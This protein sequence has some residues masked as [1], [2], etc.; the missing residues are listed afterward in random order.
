MRIRRITA[1]R[2][3][4][5]D[6]GQFLVVGLVQYPLFEYIQPFVQLQ[7]QR[8]ELGVERADQRMQHPDRVAAELRPDRACLAQRVKGRAL[9]AAQR[10][11]ESGGVVA[12]HFDGLAELLIEAETDEHDSVPV[13]L[14]LCALA[15]LF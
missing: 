1:A 3:R 4:I 8:G 5:G 11:Q 15:E 6:L 10:D 7:G 12:V 13:D 2:R 14:Q 9:R